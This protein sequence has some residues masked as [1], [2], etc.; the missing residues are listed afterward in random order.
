MSV[1]TRRPSDVRR[2]EDGERPVQGLRHGALRLSG[3]RRAGLQDD[4]RNQDQRQRSG[5][6]HRPQ[7]LDAAMTQ[8]PSSHGSDTVSMLAKSFSFCFKNT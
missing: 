8:P 6:P 4:E 3:E 2:R 7:R 1:G 5:R